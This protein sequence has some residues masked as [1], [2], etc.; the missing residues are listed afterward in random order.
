M[1]SNWQAGITGTHTQLPAI[2]M[3]DV[4][5]ESLWPRQR[6][7][8][9]GLEQGAKPFGWRRCARQCAHTRPCQVTRVRCQIY[10]GDT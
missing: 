9:G 6:Y 7:K 3:M 10:F 8:W 4:G 5:L 1:G 2:Q